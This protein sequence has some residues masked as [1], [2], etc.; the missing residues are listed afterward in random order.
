MRTVD[1][2]D[3]HNQVKCLE[4]AIRWLRSAL[5]ALRQISAGYLIAE[6]DQG[7]TCRNT[8]LAFRSAPDAVSA[9]P[10][11]VESLVMGSKDDAPV[12]FISSDGLFKTQKTRSDEP[13]RRFL[14]A[15]LGWF[16]APAICLIQIFGRRQARKK[17]WLAL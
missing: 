5:S 13:L 8:G 6:F 16:C 3:P 17:P 14:L 9:M 1:R 12:F 10:W 15:V 7:V 11:Y 2:R 4:A